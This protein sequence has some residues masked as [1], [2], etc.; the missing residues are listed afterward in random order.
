M[1]KARRPIE[2]LFIATTFSVESIGS[3]I[4][5][6][7]ADLRTAVINILRIALGFLALLAVAFLVAGG[8]DYVIAGDSEVVRIRARRIIVYSLISLIIVL[9]AWAIVSFVIKTTAE[10][11]A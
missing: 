2:R 5:V 7:Q 6:S 11:T 8:I 9:L 3:Q 10:V 4:G 1:V